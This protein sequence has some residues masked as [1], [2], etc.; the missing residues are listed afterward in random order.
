MSAV[1]DSVEEIGD[2][3]FSEES[4]FTFIGDPKDQ[5]MVFLEKGDVVRYRNDD[6]ELEAF[7]VAS[8]PGSEYVK[9]RK[10]EDYYEYISVTCIAEK[11]ED[12]E[13][14]EGYRREEEVR[15][16]VGN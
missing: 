6:K 2:P 11:V 10:T 5:N 16:G 13:I 7:F 14:S 12:P 1:D 3:E 15:T 9:I 4:V 8:K